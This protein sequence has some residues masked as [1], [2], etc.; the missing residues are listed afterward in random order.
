MSQFFASDGQSIRVLASASVLPMNIQDWEEQCL[1]PVLQTLV[2]FVSFFQ[3]MVRKIFRKLV[4]AF[5][6]LGCLWVHNCATLRSAS[7]CASLHI[8]ARGSDFISQEERSI[9][10]EMQNETPVLPSGADSFMGEWGQEP[11]DDRAGWGGLCW[12]STEG[13]LGTAAIA[14]Q[15]GRESLRASWRK[16]QLG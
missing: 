13:T 4:N 9:R 10:H 8:P 11:N 3:A 15:R 2:L 7:V 12:R 16:W 14:A 5:L 1:S 6:S